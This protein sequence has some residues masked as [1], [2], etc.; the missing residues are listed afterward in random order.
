MP[1]RSG[2]CSLLSTDF[3]ARPTSVIPLRCIL[4]M[5][6]WKKSIAYWRITASGM[7]VFGLRKEF[8]WAIE[9]KL[10]EDEARPILWHN[11]T[12]T[13]WQAYV[14]GYSLMANS[15]YNGWRMEDV[16]LDKQPSI[17][18][19]VQTMG[20]APANGRWTEMMRYLGRSQW[21]RHCSSPW[22]PSRRWPRNPT[23]S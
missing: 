11:R 10:A 8:V 9:R 15:V 14:K 5:R 6:W 3:S 16:W 22:R 13:C 19:R 1:L 17:R 12:G 7:A 2:S 23:A 20:R 18:V 4:S 21:R